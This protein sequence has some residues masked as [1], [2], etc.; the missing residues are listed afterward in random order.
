MGMMV[1]VYTPMQ[2]AVVSGIGI[3]A[4]YNGIERG[5]V[6]G[7]RM[8]GAVARRLLSESELL[9]LKLWHGVGS[10]LSADRRQRLFAAIERAPKA[11]TVRIDDVLIVD[12]GRAR[13]LLAARARKLDEAEAIIQR[14]KGMPGDEAIFSG[15]RISVR[16]IAAML[17]GDMDVAEIREY[18]PALTPYMIELAEIWNAAHPARGQPKT[19]ADYGFEAKSSERAPPKGGH[20]A[21]ARGLSA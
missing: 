4:V 9:R 7:G 16:L 20:L 15:M 8:K 1:R 19:L 21:G 3:K 10:A 18:Y 17:A 14:V 11:A 5:I 6:E 13:R 12:V 2:A